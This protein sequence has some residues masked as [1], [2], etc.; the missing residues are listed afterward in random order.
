VALTGTAIAYGEVRGLIGASIALPALWLK[1][2]AEERFLGEQF[3]ARYEAYR[4][5]VKALIPFLL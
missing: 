5:D 3:G 2:R 4:R 1:A